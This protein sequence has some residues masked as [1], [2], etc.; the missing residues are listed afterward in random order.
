MLKNFLLFGPYFFLL[1]TISDCLFANNQDPNLILRCQPALRLLVKGAKQKGAVTDPSK[2]ISVE[3]TV[4]TMVGQ[5]DTGKTDRAPVFSRI[6]PENIEALFTHVYNPE[7]S[8]DLLGAKGILYRGVDGEWKVMMWPTG[9]GARGNSIHHRDAV[10]SVLAHEAQLLETLALEKDSVGVLA[11]QQKLA[12][13]ARELSL[14]RRSDSFSAETLGKFSGFQMTA[15]KNSRTGKLEILSIDLDSSL[16]TAQVNE[17]INQT[18]ESVNELMGTIASAIDPMIR[19]RTYRIFKSQ[20]ANLTGEE[21]LAAPEGA[22][23]EELVK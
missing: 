18:T 11:L 23:L 9:Q 17:N 14:I 3:E 13:L 5:V 16:T 22:R 20:R 2:T 10:A 19:P 15:R 21:R 8:S 1:W 12:E 7:Q 6:T 4:P